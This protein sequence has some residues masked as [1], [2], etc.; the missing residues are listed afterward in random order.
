MTKFDEMKAIQG[1]EGKNPVLQL[2]EHLYECRQGQAMQEERVL[3]QLE[4]T[5]NCSH[6]EPHHHI[7]A[8][9]AMKAMTP[10]MA[11]GPKT[12]T[13]TMPKRWIPESRTATKATTHTVAPKTAMTS[14]ANFEG[15]FGSSNCIYFLF[16]WMAST[17]HKPSF[18]CKH[19]GFE[20]LSFF[21][22]HHCMKRG[23]TRAL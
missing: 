18:D 16:A 5:R 8:Q 23:G 1:Q 11:T 13:S 15:P 3:R 10:K 21:P 9:D 17:A 19:L 7:L 20:M 4:R 22:C 12:A 14:T 2:A 6:K